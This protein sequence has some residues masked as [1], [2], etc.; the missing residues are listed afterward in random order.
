MSEAFAQF[1]DEAARKQRDQALRDE[2]RIAGADLDSFAEEW[3]EAY[4]PSD[5]DDKLAQFSSAM[6]RIFLVLDP[7]SHYA[8]VGRSGLQIGCS[9]GA[10]GAKAMAKDLEATVREINKSECSIC[11]P[12]RVIDLQSETPKPTG[13]ACSRCGSVKMAHRGGCPE[14]LDCGYKEPCGGG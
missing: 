8:I 14:C 7:P 13:N 10:S 12:R 2:A 3:V 9:A 1:L 6:R 4:P 5:F 11:S